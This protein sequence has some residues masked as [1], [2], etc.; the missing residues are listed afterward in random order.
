MTFKIES[1][2]C[3]GSFNNNIRNLGWNVGRGSSCR[4]S[5]LL[6]YRVEGSQEAQDLI[7]RDKI[8][9]DWF[10]VWCRPKFNVFSCETS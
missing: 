9:S 7:S 5:L 4:D 1:R 2:R 6:R 8:E 3:H 10:A